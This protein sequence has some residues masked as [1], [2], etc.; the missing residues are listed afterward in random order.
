MY[1]LMIVEDESLAREAIIKMIDFTAFGFEVVAVCEDGQQA[2]E[3]YFQLFPDLVITDINMPIV[4]GLQL[5]GQIAE[6]DRGTR[7]VIITG[8]DDFNYARQAIKNKVTSYILKPVTPSEF[9]DVLQEARQALDEQAKRRQKVRLDE[10]LIYRVSPLVRDQIMNRLI[11]GTVDVAEV[12]GDVRSFG[13]DPGQPVFLIGLVQIDRPDETA[14]SLNISGQLLQFMV[15]N[16]VDEL[17]RLVPQ[18]M[19][20]SLSDGKVAIAAS[21]GHALSLLLQMQKLGE[22]VRDTMWDLL[23]IAVNVGIG[24]PVGSLGQITD[25]Y[26]E[27]LNCLDY[28]F[29]LPARSVITPDAIKQRGE[30]IDFSELEDSIL[31]QVRL[32]SE[33]QTQAMVTNLIQVMRLSY[34]S[35]N[36]IQFEITRLVNR[37]LAT[38]KSETGGIPE[39]STVLPVAGDSDYLL[40]MQKWLTRFCQGCI[41]FLRARRHG[42]VRRLSTMAMQY[43]K[44]HY[45]DSQLSLMAVCSHLSVSL[46]YF[47]TFFKEE[48]GK[49][50]VEYLTQVRMEKA[51]DL[52]LNTDR[53]LYAIAEQVGYENPAYFTV[54]FKK[55]TGLGPREFRKSF[56][57][58]G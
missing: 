11:L 17:T 25:S 51:K 29:L 28:R 19:A 39:L 22:K 30:P 33:D 24:N 38:L 45:M 47:S 50:F 40:K 15:Q 54:A 12:A 13:L 14:Q 32:Q 49:T 56:G 46:S 20:F 43:I 44:E 6:A 26:H 52:L 4:S 35:K 3:Q 48:T 57:R 58:E 21:A 31:L 8:Y 7:V 1:K 18:F 23:N 34:L 41:D 16:V 55:Q 2:A 10:Q 5:A 9:R 42:E 37:L 53:M 27:A 36:D